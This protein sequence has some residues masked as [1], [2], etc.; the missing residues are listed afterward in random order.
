MSA[1]FL[2]MGVEVSAEDVT[3]PAGMRQELKD[4]DLAGDV[5]VRIR[6]PN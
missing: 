2:A 3:G 6:A 1:K 4:R 5:L